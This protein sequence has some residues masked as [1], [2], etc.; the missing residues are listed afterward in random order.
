MRV[1]VS[2]DKFK[3][4]LTAPQA[5]SALG[6]GVR[7]ALPDADVRLLPVADGGEGTVDALLAA[8]GVRR[9]AW[10]RDP[11]GRPVTVD[12]AEVDGAAVIELAAA[13]GLRHVRP[14]DSTA[15][16]A[17]TYGTGQLIRQVLDAGLRHI[18][19][20]LGGSASTDGGTGIL[21][22]LGTRFLDAAGEPIAPGGGALARLASVDLGRLDGRLAQTKV[23]LCC[24]VR[25]PL[26]G[27]AGA[28]AVFAPQKGASTASVATLEHGLSRLA[29]TLRAATG[30]DAAALDWGGAA[31]GCAGGLH[32]V[33]GATF[34]PGFDLLADLVGLDRHLA[35][36]DLVLVGEGSLDSQSLAGKAP[37]AL[38]VRAA[39][40]G[41]PVVAVAGRVDVDATPLRELGILAALGAVD[42]AG[43][44]KAALADPARWTQAAAER[45]LG[46]RIGDRLR[47]NPAGVSRQPWA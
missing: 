19:L 10:V 17:D 6:A 3:G 41:V 5:A 44:V 28:A 15:V 20:G 18:V 40:L 47:D 8:G 35:W 9:T 25:S 46:M 34:A 38:S 36:A 16:A 30:R 33:L 27:P 31:G 45:V 37:I 21:R 7:R 42:V 14:D 12:W 11:L 1:L 4:T 26:L 29:A 2:P 39:R 43:S 23:T 32:A 22:A 13:S 24:D